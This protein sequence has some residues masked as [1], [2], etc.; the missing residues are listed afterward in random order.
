MS[1]KKLSTAFLLSSLAV[2]ANAAVVTIVNP[3][4][5]GVDAPQENISDSNIDGIF[6]VSENSGH[7]LIFLGVHETNG[8]NSGSNT[9]LDVQIS[10]VGN[11]ITGNFS[12]V[13]SGVDAL[14][15]DIS[16]DSSRHN[17][18]SVF[19]FSGGSTQTVTFNGLA[20][21]GAVN[22]ENSA[23]VGVCGYSLPSGQTGCNTEELLG[24]DDFVA[25]PFGENFL[26]EMTDLTVNNFSGAYYADGFNVELASVAT[27]PVPAAAF[28]FGSGILSLFAVRRK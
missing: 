23:F 12:L 6:D 21:S 26:A 20:S 27:V 13:L 17:L 25:N 15:W 7:E 10:S 24:I 28:L 9:T 8:S 14:T 11:G 16:Y 22:V 3:N 5:N 18:Q 1:I 2:S 4:A 19:V